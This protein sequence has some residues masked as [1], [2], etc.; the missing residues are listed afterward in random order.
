MNVQ[1]D[2]RHVV[3]EEKQIATLKPTKRNSIIISI[4]IKC[5]QNS[6]DIL[7]RH[8]VCKK[9]SSTPPLPDVSV[10]C[11]TWA[12]AADRRCLLV[13]KLAGGGAGSTGGR[14]LGGTISSL[15]VTSGT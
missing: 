11:L 3:S 6:H 13:L 8:W 4:I 7:Q 15:L 12:G 1:T 10:V 14:M 9:N 5:N 2:W